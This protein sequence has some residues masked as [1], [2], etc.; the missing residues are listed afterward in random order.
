MLKRKI[1]WFSG[2][3]RRFGHFF[4]QKAIKGCE[5]LFHAAFLYKVS[6]EGIEVLD[7]CLVRLFGTLYH[8]IVCEKNF[9]KF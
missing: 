8:G 2:R 5:S 4:S 6:N 7:F 3:K 9:D 1:H